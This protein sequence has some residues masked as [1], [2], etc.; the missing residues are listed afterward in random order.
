MTFLSAEVRRNPYPFYQQMRSGSPAVHD[1]GSDSWMIFDY[2]GVKRALND[3]EAFSSSMAN[4]G[5]GNP[6][7]FIFLDPPR[8][9]KLRNLVLRAFTSRTVACLEPRIREL[10]RQLLD[11]TIGRGEME[12]AA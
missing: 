10:S 11:Q 7:W 2:D 12:M 6:P 1:P 9:T 5:R 3:H 4:A 8:H